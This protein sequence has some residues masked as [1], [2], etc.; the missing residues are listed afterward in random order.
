MTPMKQSIIYSETSIPNSVIPANCEGIHY[1][2]LVATGTHICKGDNLILF[3]FHKKDSRSPCLPSVKLGDY[4]FSSPYD[5]VVY[6]PIG[7]STYG[8]EVGAT[9]IKLPIAI[10][11]TLEEIITSYFNTSYEILNDEFTAEKRIRWNRVAGHG[12]VVGYT[13]IVP[14]KVYDGFLI[15]NDILLLLTTSNNQP[16]LS[17][18]YDKKILSIRKK[19]SLIFKFDDGSFIS[20][21]VTET[22]SNTNSSKYNRSVCIPLFRKDIEA[23]KNKGWDLLKVEHFN[24]DESVILR[25]KYRNDYQSP[26]SGELFKRYAMKYI[27][28]LTEM[29][30]DMIAADVV[31]E[32]HEEIPIPTDDECYV[33]LMVDTTNG[34]HKIGISNHPEYREKTLQSEKP[35]IEK[36]CAKCFPS[37]QIALAIE[38][39]LHST[40]AS[41]RIRGE[42]F[43]LSDADVSQVI[44]TLK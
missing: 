33:Y 28:A 40:F 26:F 42:W 6:N 23:F 27:E 31:R 4:V 14:L 38:S 39:A 32:S 30:V 25:N 16:A 44:Q 36:V 35:S 34:F 8:F 7:D 10:Y 41:K 21:P 18:L 20:F 19:D 15:E 11:T 43:N 5:G 29:G 9:D 22:P 1:K 2:C 24:G 13:P 3:S 17:V 37:R 12:L